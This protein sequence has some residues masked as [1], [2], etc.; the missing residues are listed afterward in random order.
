[1]TVKRIYICRHGYRMNWLPEPHPPNP[2]GIDLD[3]PLA[4]HGVDQAEELAHHLVQLPPDQRPQFILSSPFYR[5]V[6]TAQPITKA[7]DTKVALERGVGEYYRVGRNVIP[8]P[9]NYD[10][11][12]GFFPDVLVDEAE[13][14]RDTA[15]GV[16]PSLEGESPEAIFD[17][18]QRFWRLFFPVF[19]AKYPDVENVLIVTHAAT[20]IALGMSLIGKL[21][22]LESIDDTPN[23]F[24]RAGAC[25]MST[26]VRDHDHWKLTVNGDTLFLREGEEMN[27]NFHLGFEAGLDEDIKLRKKQEEETEVRKQRHS[28]Y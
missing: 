24:I 15:V 17:R 22:V 3:P 28:K 8:E 12:Q 21:S 23:N 9:A 16:I 10:R 2:T 4:P 25:S 19:E 5:C 20:A 6:E 18:C 1:M 26:Y 27:W 7:L 13:W 14:P 11:L